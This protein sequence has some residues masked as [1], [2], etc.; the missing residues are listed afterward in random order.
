MS[1]PSTGVALGAGAGQALKAARLSNCIP[2][3]AARLLTP[4]FRLGG[5]HPLVVE[6]GEDGRPIILSGPGPRLLTSLF[7]GHCG[8]G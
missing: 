2:C 5:R 8:L 6:E 4:V 3:P 7:P 1:M